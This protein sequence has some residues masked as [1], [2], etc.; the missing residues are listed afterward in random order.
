MFPYQEVRE[1]VLKQIQ[2]GIWK[3]GD[4]LPSEVALAATLE[5]H[6]LTVNR[7]MRELSQAGQVKRLRGV[8]TIVAFEKES[9]NP[10][11]TLRTF[12][13]GLVGLVAGHSFNPRTNPFYG[14]IFEG[15]R[16]ELQSKGFFLTPMGDIAEFLELLAGPHGKEV[17]GSLSALAILGP[18]DLKTRP[19]LEAFNLPVVVV[20]V[21]EYLGPLPSIASDDAKDSAMLTDK[22]FAAGRR[23]VVHVNA[24]GCS[25]L[26]SRLEGFL[27][28]SEAAGY[29]VPF[30]Y[31]LEAD[32]LEIEDGRIAMQQFLETK[33]PFDAVFGGNDNL[34]WGAMQALQES[35]ISVPEDVS[36]VGFDGINLPSRLTKKLST[37][38]VPR[39]KMGQLAARTLSDLCLGVSIP[40]RILR[41]SS[42]WFGGDTLLEAMTPHRNSVARLRESIPI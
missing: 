18:I 5:V 22:I 24:V 28:A 39:F 26:Q 29:P 41:L 9:E 27:S 21:S 15:L 2:D 34:A 36:V 6:R 19:L 13:N 40:N 17:E 33:L 10:V 4:H 8:G 32:G 7:V 20:G 42:E 25:R 12:R 14:E 23:K 31:I 35:G 38:R 30:R 16:K 3:P 37:M 11:D 1:Y